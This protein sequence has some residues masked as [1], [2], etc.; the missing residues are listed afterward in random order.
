[1][2]KTTRSPNILGHKVR[3]SDSKVI[4]FGIS[5]S[6][7]EFTKKLGK[8]KNK[9]LSKFWK[10]AKSKK[11]SQKGEIYLNLMLKKSF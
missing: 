5:S 10:T 3:N 6:G 2:L 8:S 9:K 11:N 7:K 1:M 4:K